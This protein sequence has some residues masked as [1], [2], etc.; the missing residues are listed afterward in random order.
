MTQLDYLHILFND[1][2][3]TIESRNAWLTARYKRIIN[4][5]GDLTMPERSSTIERLKD[6]R[7]SRNFPNRKEL[8]D[9]ERD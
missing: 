8:R 7:E 4:Y 2:G 6:I 1:L 3:F 9:T 5:L